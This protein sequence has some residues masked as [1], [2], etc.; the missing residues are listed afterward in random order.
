MT[1]LKIE[2]NMITYHYKCNKCLYSYEIQQSIKEKSITLCPSCKTESCERVIYAPIVIDLGPKTIGTQAERNSKKM[3]KEL[4]DI[5]RKEDKLASRQAR[6]YMADTTRPV[7]H[8]NKKITNTEINRM[9]KSE[10]DKYI[11]E[12]KK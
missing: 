1:Q 2:T 8:H 6:K 3:S 12:G 5:K 9:T 11:V 10:L 4:L 7:H